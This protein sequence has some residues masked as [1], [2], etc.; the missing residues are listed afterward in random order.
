[1]FKICG[2]KTLT[3][4]GCSRGDHRICEPYSMAQMLFLKIEIR[5]VADF[6]TEGNDFE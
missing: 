4:E 6:L 3:G 5:A 1:M 2:K